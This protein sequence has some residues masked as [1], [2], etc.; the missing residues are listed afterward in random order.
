[1]AE[2]KKTETKKDV[3]PIAMFELVEVT[4]QTANV[5]RDNSTGKAITAEQALV[6]ILN[7]VTAIKKGVVG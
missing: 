4:T 3:K 7:E 2:E 6:R 5:I 1:M